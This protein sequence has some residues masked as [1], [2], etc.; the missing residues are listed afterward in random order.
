MFTDPAMAAGPALEDNDSIAHGEIGDTLTDRGYFAY[1]L[2]SEM[3]GIL[4]PL[5]ESCLVGTVFNTDGCDML[6]HQYEA[7]CR[8]RHRAINN[9]RFAFLNP[10]YAIE[11]GHNYWPAKYVNVT[12]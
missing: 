4:M 7:R 1:T 3:L 11:F 10:Q 8:F 9:F 5:C 2:M 12:P 6:S